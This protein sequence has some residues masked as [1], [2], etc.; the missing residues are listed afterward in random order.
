M[1]NDKAE[2]LKSMRVLQM[3]IPT[4]AKYEIREMDGGKIIMGVPIL[5]PGRWRDSNTMTE[6]IY[7]PK[8][9]Q[10]YSVI[11]NGL[12]TR[13]PGGVPRSALEKVGE[14]RDVYYGDNPNDTVGKA[15]R[16]NIF[17]HARTQDSRDAL[18]LMEE[19][20]VSSLSVEHGGKESW[21]SEEKAYE[22]HNIDL[23]GSAQVDVGACE[24]AS[25][26][27]SELH[28]LD[29]ERQRDDEIE[30]GGDTIDEKE[31]EEMKEKLTALEKSSAEK[32]G[33]IKELSE[34]LEKAKQGE[35]DKQLAAAMDEIKELKA[36]REKDEERIK[37]LENMP[38]PKSTGAGGGAPTEL[39]DGYPGVTFKR[40]EIYDGRRDMSWQT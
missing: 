18:T 17:Y 4:G 23:Y 14:K 27:F 3:P 16:A 26:L 28:P 11:R 12:W 13:H 8:S 31:F 40:D 7:T 29:A 24:G 1:T 30:Q 10:N 15:L 35:G 36:A 19:G 32:D 5:S 34:N 38:D 33:Q 25:H 9:L 22:M 6:C 21:N 2:P 39:E 20:I 37:A